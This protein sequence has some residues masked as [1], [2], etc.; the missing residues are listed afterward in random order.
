LRATGNPGTVNICSQRNDGGYPVATLASSTPGDRAN[1]V[2][3]GVA[4]L[5]DRAGIGV[6]GGRNENVRNQQMIG[7]KSGIAALQASHGLDQEGRSEDQNQ[8]ESDFGDNQQLAE[9]LF[10]GPRR[11]AST[12]LAQR[13]GERYASPGEG[14]REPEQDRG[15]D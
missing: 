11:A 9:R 6:A 12:A 2:L 5:R 10:F 13:F 15:E 8:R 1:A 14:R 3:K 4:E 7:T